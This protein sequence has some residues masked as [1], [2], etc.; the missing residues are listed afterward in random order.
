MT[1]RRVRMLPWDPLW[2][3]RHVGHP[4][5]PRGYRGLP[6][7]ASLS[8]AGSEGIS[9]GQMQEALEVLV[10]PEAKG[11]SASVIG[12]LKREWESEY[13]EWCRRDVGKDRWV[14]WWADGIYSGLRA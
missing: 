6:A 7:F 10:G 12:R 5:S 8:M 4:V 2:R 1:G 14:Y 3:L 9:T 11:L 13:T